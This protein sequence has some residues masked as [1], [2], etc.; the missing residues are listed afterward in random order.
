L[1]FKI[2]GRLKEHPLESLNTLG[3]ILFQWREE[4]VRECGGLL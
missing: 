1:F 4:A 2:I 3:K